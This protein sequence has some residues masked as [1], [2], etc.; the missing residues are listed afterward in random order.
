MQ[1]VLRAIAVPKTQKAAVCGNT[2]RSTIFL[3]LTI[4]SIA[5]FMRPAYTI[6]NYAGKK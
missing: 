2:S 5:A 4:L 6:T 3:L 1:E